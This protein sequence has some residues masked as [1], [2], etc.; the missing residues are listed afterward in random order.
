MRRLRSDNGNLEHGVGADLSLY[1]R[2]SD[3][4]ADPRT[5]QPHFAFRRLCRLDLDLFL[6]C[7]AAFGKW[8]LSGFGVWNARAQH[9]SNRPGRTSSSAIRAAGWGRLGGGDRGGL[10]SFDPQGDGFLPQSRHRLG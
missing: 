2:A 4:I 8:L 1:R 7:F 3:E 9:R 5:R 10:P 6:D